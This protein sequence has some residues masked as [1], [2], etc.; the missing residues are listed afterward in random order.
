MQIDKLMFGNRGFKLF[1]NAK[2]E[3]MVGLTLPVPVICRQ[4]D[5]QNL[6]TLVNLLKK[7]KMLVLDRLN[8]TWPVLKILSDNEASFPSITGLHIEFDPAYNKLIED[9]PPNL[10][11]RCRTLSLVMGNV[12]P[13]SPE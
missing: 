1:E 4:T 9:L 5:R 13:S 11:K 12:M 3:E 6:A 7:T 10:L 8:V 2:L